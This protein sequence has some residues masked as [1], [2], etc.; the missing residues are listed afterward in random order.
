[1]G[2]HEN[3]GL[4]SSCAHSNSP[5]VVSA[6]S[7]TYSREQKTDSLVEQRNSSQLAKEQAL[8][9]ACYLAVPANLELRHTAAVSQSGQLPRCQRQSRSVDNLCEYIGMSAASAADELQFQERSYVNTSSHNTTSNQ[10][11]IYSYARTPDLMLLHPP[12]LRS[13]AENT[14]LKTGVL[15]R[16]GSHPNHLDID[17]HNSTDVTRNLE[18]FDT[19]SMSQETASRTAVS[20]MELN[21]V[22]SRVSDSVMETDVPGI[23]MSARSR[24]FTRQKSSAANADFSSPSS[25]SHV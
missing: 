16:T 24:V 6:S 25:S 7:P 4:S 22:K 19:S 13:T 14:S 20:P 9:G 15:R 10:G 21:P 17:Q 23:K 2:S 8:D 12:P 11:D 3:T 5:S 18:M 1:M